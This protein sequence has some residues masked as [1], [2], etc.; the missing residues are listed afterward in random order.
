MYTSR[1]ARRKLRWPKR[2]RHVRQKTPYQLPGAMTPHMW[3]HGIQGAFLRHSNNTLWEGGG[4]RGKQSPCKNSAAA[5]G[6]ATHE[7][8]YKNRII[9]L[10]YFYWVLHLTAVFDSCAPKRGSAFLRTDEMS[11]FTAITK[12]GSF[13]RRPTYDRAEVVS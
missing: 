5:P 11:F 2:N 4:R 9:R 1:F 12:F 7:Y 8:I 6:A 3:T 10:V 13:R